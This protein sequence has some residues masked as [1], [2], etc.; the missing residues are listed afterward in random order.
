M[1]KLEKPSWETADIRRIKNTGESV[2]APLT[3]AMCRIHLASPLY[4]KPPESS[5][6]IE[7]ARRH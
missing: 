5:T 3:Q 7:V 2:A 1:N 4:A 6:H